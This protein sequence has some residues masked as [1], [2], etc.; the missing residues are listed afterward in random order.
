MLNDVI[1]VFKGFFSRS[2]WF[3]NFL[4]VAMF[5]FLHLCIAWL[6]IPGISLT[7]WVQADPKA[8]TYFP[9]TFAAL[10]VLAYA[11]TP[12]IPWF[13]VCWM[14]RSCQSEFTRRYAANTS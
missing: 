1:G 9:M 10:V 8:L 13:E 2:F 4:P 3:G 12:I 6:V 7:T 14:A 5:S 11:L